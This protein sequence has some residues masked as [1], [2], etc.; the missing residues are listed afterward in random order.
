MLRHT[1]PRNPASTQ[2]PLT[3]TPEP[4]QPRAVWGT[5][6]KQP[7]QRTM[8]LTRNPG[9]ADRFGIPKHTSASLTEQHVTQLPKVLR[10]EMRAELPSLLQ[11]R[12]SR[13][14][15]SIRIYPALAV[16]ARNIVRVRHVR[17]VRHVRNMFPRPGTTFGANI[18][19]NSSRGGSLRNV[20]RCKPGPTVAF[21][22]LQKY[23]QPICLWLRHPTARPEMEASLSRQRHR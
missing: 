21:R 13:L 6:G 4:L 9:P 15:G 1:A 3:G 10:E 18:A 14:P 20:D 16:L 17:H 22:Q 2:Q 5:T 12:I 23:C 19:F 11:L 8:V 7:Q